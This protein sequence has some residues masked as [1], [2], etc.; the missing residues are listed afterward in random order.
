[1]RRHRSFERDFP[2]IV[3]LSCL[4]VV[5]AARAMQCIIFTL[6]TVYKPVPGL[7]DIRTVAVTYAG[8]LLIE[9]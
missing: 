1:M 2:H 7:G 9:T 5:G 8:I 3:E 4:V 6:A